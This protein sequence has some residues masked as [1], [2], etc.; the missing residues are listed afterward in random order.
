[1]KRINFTSLW[2]IWKGYLYYALG[3]ILFFILLSEIYL[4]GVRFEE[5]ANDL[6]LLLLSYA[7]VGCIT[8]I[9]ILRRIW[10]SKTI[11]PMSEIWKGGI[12]LLHATFGCFLFV[13]TCLEMLSENFSLDTGDVTLGCYIYAHEEIYIYLCLY[14][15]AA[16]ILFLIQVFRA[17]CSWLRKCW[18]EMVDLMWKQ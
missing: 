16:T 11:I 5:T 2:E 15:A 10:K 4:K 9:V 7:A 8:V 6:F 3:V 14:T 1:M 13:V 18:F 17:V 12:L